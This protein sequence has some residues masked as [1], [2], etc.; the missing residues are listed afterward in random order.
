ML[1]KAAAAL[2]AAT[3]KLMQWF[4]SGQLEMVPLY[5]T[6]YLEMLAETTLG[7]L[8]LEQAVLGEAKRAELPEGHADH[9]FFL[10]KHHIALYFAGNVLPGVADKAELLNI[11]DRSA[12]EIPDACFATV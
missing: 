11:A 4:F 6:R 9:A 7:W 10:G 8:L 3:M 1:A 12:L 2:Q 5:S